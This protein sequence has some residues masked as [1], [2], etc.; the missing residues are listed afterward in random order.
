MT[1]EGQYL[2]GRSG[3]SRRTHMTERRPVPDGW[4]RVR[5]SDVATVVMGQSP[6]GTTVS[7][8]REATPEDGG[9][10]FLQGN[11]EFGRS[12]PAPTKWCYR[13]SK[14]SAAGDLLISV[15][16]PVGHTNRADQ[17][18]AIGRGL[19]AVGFLHVSPDF[20]W[21][22]VN[23]AKKALQRLAQGS[24]FGAI[25]GK[26]LRQL[27][28]PLP[29]LHEQQAIA[30]TLNVI[31]EA[32]GRAENIIS[33]TENL[34]DALRQELL[35][36]GLPGHHTGWRE[37][38]KL[39]TIP[40]SWST[41]KVEDVA[42]VVGGS[43]PARSKPENW[44]GDI[45]WLT[46]SEISENTGM[47]ISR[48]REKL[49]AAG[50]RTAGLSLLPKGSVLLTSRATIGA[51]AVATMATTTNQGFQNLVPR[52]R[53]NPLWLYYEMTHSKQRL[54]ALAAGS[55]FREVSRRA[56]ATLD[57]PYPPLQEQKAIA[58][59]LS[60]VDGTI[61]QAANQLQAM[62]RL[63]TAMADA[64]LTGRLRVVSARG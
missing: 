52:E 40:C 43:T 55:T 48:S 7:D 25:N 10:P 31:D 19:A 58:G 30:T 4:N 11:A 64:L 6:P 36:R 60:R 47:Y 33:V 14:V 27:T 16:A 13:P 50:R 21:H 24:T 45:P 1:G 9:L 8:L 37:V 49:T 2:G 29:P 22:A 41:A 46:P 38:P 32:I 12:C 57:I 42:E 56:V 62:V 17:P 44:G 54:K 28:F 5:L 51:T 15:R 20:G 63:R 59:V 18:L 3:D 53:T 35:T 23:R 34:L 26:E 61:E 39:G